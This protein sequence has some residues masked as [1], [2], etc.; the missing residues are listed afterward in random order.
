MVYKCA[1]CGKELLAVEV[2]ANIEWRIPA[3]EMYCQ[4]CADECAVRLLALS[5][6]IQARA[7]V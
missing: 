3:P 5:E 6:T 4:D 2:A 7:K 1:R